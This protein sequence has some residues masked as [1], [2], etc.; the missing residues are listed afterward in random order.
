MYR[1]IFLKDFDF[2]K[3]YFMG[4]IYMYMYVVAACDHYDTCACTCVPYSRKFC[5]VN[6]ATI[7]HR[8]IWQNFFHAVKITTG[9]FL[10]RFRD[11][12]FAHESKR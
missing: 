6:P 11:K 4:C 5:L 2:A 9:I 8:N 10:K 1:E 12:N 3:K 7:A